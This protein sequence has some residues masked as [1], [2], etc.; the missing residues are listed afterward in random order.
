[1]SV[2]FSRLSGSILSSW[3]SVSL[4]KGWPATNLLRYARPSTAP[5]TLV[6]MTPERRCPICSIQSSLSDSHVI[7]RLPP[8]QRR[9]WKG[10]LFLILNLTWILYQRTFLTHSHSGIL[11][12][13][14]FP[15]LILSVS[16]AGF[17][18][19]PYESIDSP[20][21]CWSTWLLSVPCVIKSSWE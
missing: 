15:A 3:N 9:F 12:L 6:T 8:S 20:W 19:G 2:S 14:T 18:L 1:M 13:P 4:W 10:R 5:P 17:T 21:K 7:V 11:N 16:Y